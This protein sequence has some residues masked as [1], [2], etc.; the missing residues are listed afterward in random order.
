MS[1]D[2][3]AAEAAQQTRPA[4]RRVLVAGNWKMHHDHLETIR[5]LQELGLRLPEG[6]SSRVE[7]VVHP[8]FT[9]LR[10]AQTTI[11]DRGLPLVL[12][13][14]HCYHQDAGA[15]T[16]EVAPPMLARL[17][18]RYVLVG[19]SERRRLF[20]QDDQQ[21]AATLQA[22]RRHGMVPVLCVGETEEERAAGATEER[23]AAQLTA[24]L[25]GLDGEAVSAL[26]VAYEPVWAIG[27]GQTATPEDAQAA[28]A[29]IRGR[30]VEAHGPE[31]AAVR[32]LYGGSVT[33]ETTLELLRG[34]D[35]DGLLV[36][37][38]SLRADS[39]AAIVQAAMGARSTPR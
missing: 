18:V 30:L 22:I 14:Q 21:V 4:P 26:V 17:G 5:T 19:H 7:V 37:G 1:A 29:F 13:A 2:Q 9:D 38:A 35:V 16:G 32:L 12:G 20:G 6:A 3:A 31:A 39:F 11:E 25:A 36:G 33:P 10:S 23:L 28:C 15:F 8:P 24:A 27:T 34:R